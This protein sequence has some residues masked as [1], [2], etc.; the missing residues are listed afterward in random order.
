MVRR[1]DEQPLNAAAGFAIRRNPGVAMLWI[2]REFELFRPPAGNEGL[3][4]QMGT[5]DSVEWWAEGKPA[6]REQ[7]LH[8][9]D[10]GLS[11]LEA[12]ARQEK[13][14]LEAL[15]NARSRFEKWIPQN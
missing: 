10:E 3:L 8:S 7:V 6:T 11:N 1:E 13:G 14:G 4:I 15:A 5:P 2:T 9:I 12:I